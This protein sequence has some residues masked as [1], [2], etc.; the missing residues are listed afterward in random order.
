M[1]TCDNKMSCL[2]P[3]R[4]PPTRRWRFKG[5]PCGCILF[6]ARRSSG[7][8]GAGAH[9]S[10]ELLAALTGLFARRTA[11]VSGRAGREEALHTVAW[12]FGRPRRSAAS[13]G[14]TAR[15]DKAR[16]FSSGTASFS[17]RLRAPASAL[18]GSGSGALGASEALAQRNGLPTSVCWWLT[19]PTGASSVLVVRGSQKKV[20]NEVA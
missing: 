6:T 13:A 4:A 7:R 3:W 15:T 8:R 10:G 11:R 19:C 17:R 2:S 9:V 20:R 14:L 18:R 12:L 5:A 16:T 1:G